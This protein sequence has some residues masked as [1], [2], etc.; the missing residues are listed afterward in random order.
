M[1]VE[2]LLHGEVPEWVHDPLLE[3]IHE[4][5]GGVR[6]EVG[7]FDQHSLNEHR[8]ADRSRSAARLAAL[9]RNAKDAAGVI[10][11]EL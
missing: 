4:A 1:I 5:H 7:G 10:K 6:G 3:G 9:I 11:N 8:A 2:V